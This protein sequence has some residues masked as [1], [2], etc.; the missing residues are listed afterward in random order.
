MVTTI[1]QLPSLDKLPTLEQLQGWTQL[2]EESQ[3]YHTCQRVFISKAGQDE[4]LEEAKKITNT[5]RA[6]VIETFALEHIITL[7]EELGPA[8]VALGL[9]PPW[10]E[11]N[12][13]SGLYRTDDH[14]VPLAI[15]FLDGLRLSKAIRHADFCESGY[16]Y[17]CA[18]PISR[19][20][21]AQ[22]NRQI[23]SH[24]TEDAEAISSYDK[25]LDNCV[26]ELI[27][28]LC[29]YVASCYKLHM[30][31]AISDLDQANVEDAIRN[32]LKAL[33]GLKTLYESESV[34]SLVEINPFD[35]HLNRL[36]AIYEYVNA[37][38][39]VEIDQYVA[40]RTSVFI[41]DIMGEQ[42]FVDDAA[43]EVNINMDD[44]Q[45]VIKNEITEIFK[46]FN[47]ERNAE[48]HL[49]DCFDVAFCAKASESNQSAA[50]LQALK[51]SGVSE[52]SGVLRHASADSARKLYAL[53]E[54]GLEKLIMTAEHAAKISS[55]GLLVVTLQALA[56]KNLCIQ[57]EHVW[58]AMMENALM[59]GD[60]A[61]IRQCLRI[62]NKAKERFITTVQH[63]K[64]LEVAGKGEG[65]CGIR[66][67]DDRIKMVLDYLN[68]NINGYCS[69][70][71]SWYHTGE[72]QRQKSVQTTALMAAI[73]RGD[74]AVANK[75]IALGADVNVTAEDG[76]SALMLAADKENEALVGKLI[77]AGANVNASDNL[78]RTAL[79]QASMR[80]YR[81]H[82]IAIVGKLIAAG[83]DINA[84]DNDGNTPLI[85]ASDYGR[86]GMVDKLIAEG[87]DVNATSHN[88]ETALIKTSK[89]GYGGIVTR[90]INAGAKID[91]VDNNG[92]TAL[93]ASFINPENSIM[94]NVASLLIDAGSA[95]HAALMAA[96]KKGNEEVVNHL[97][98]AEVDVN[99][100]ADN[101]GETALMVAC[102]GGHAAVVTQLIS[103]NAN[104]N[105]K[106]NNGSTALIEASRYGY[107]TI[108][109]QLLDAKADVDV[110]SNKGYTA[111][112]LASWRG[113]E[114][115]V[116]Q[117]LDAKDAK[118]AKADVNV[119]NN[120]GYTALMLASWRGRETIVDKLMQAGANINATSIDG[121]T[122]FI[123]A[124]SNGHEAVAGKLIIAGSNSHTVL[125]AACK[126]GN[127]K[128]VKR[129]IATKIVDVNV[130]TDD[131]FTPL[132]MACAGGHEAV[133]DKLMQAGADINAKNKEGCTA[134]SIAKKN[135]HEGVVLKLRAAMESTSKRKRDQ[136]DE[137]IRT[138][139]SAKTQKKPGIAS[140]SI[141]DSNSAPAAALQFF[142]DYSDAESSH[143][144]NPTVPPVLSP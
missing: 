98:A 74:E 87:A 34:E 93:T 126:K 81:R 14:A 86:D 94:H 18:S 1:K 55:Y 143:N 103:A 67:K 24:I 109:T 91:L 144:E 63:D 3:Q 114:T 130:A 121:H 61:V 88:G 71:T 26:N 80:P 29:N 110:I 127:E 70:F 33:Y 53:D 120:K 136:D 83:A 129:L 49:G 95:S 6:E 46:S 131:G 37:E 123:C 133:V 21:L 47:Q 38:S 50:R 69:S 42:L 106:D 124:I 76:S 60:P 75:L 64:F 102:A 23:D 117:L 15:R 139:K 115:I 41:Q 31:E 142:P 36:K 54:C 57:E 128:T 89:W 101:K 4:A 2:W 82:N 119:I 11:Q 45:S 135:N 105:A 84:K 125:M 44:T 141:E 56:K 27:K 25:N 112:M 39:L 20:R 7:K 8:F 68:I 72:Q 108:V 22:K 16:T 118:D 43:F 51:D 79:I 19:M 40:Q 32:R 99:V 104:V 113:H 111:L 17:G 12:I 132:M 35:A 97:I 140:R 5:Q 62:E 66:S 92:H 78:G 9:E 73:N 138:E 134:L 100:A 85:W 52:I 48:Q 77:A 96:C 107:E 90:L 137:A 58:I 10:S 65:L 30:D 116:T 122:P 59:G 13:A 28:R